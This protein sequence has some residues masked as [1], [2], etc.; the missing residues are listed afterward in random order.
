MSL[1]FK[2]RI[3]IYNTLAAAV[4]TLLVFIVVYGVVYITAYR[5]LDDEIRVEKEEVFTNIH[6]NGDSLVLNMMSEKLEMEHRQ[7]EVEV[8]PPLTQEQPEPRLHGLRH[9]LGISERRAVRED[10]VVAAVE[11]QIG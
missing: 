8:L 3:A 5:H 10:R 4:A 11:L 7:A 6:W 2:N 9:G 1:L